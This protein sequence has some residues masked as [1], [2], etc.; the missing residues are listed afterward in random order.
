MILALTARETDFINYSIFFKGNRLKGL[1]RLEAVLQ[2]ADLTNDLVKNPASLPLFLFDK[3]GS[4][5]DLLYVFKQYDYGDAL[6]NGYCESTNKTLDDLLDTV[7]EEALVKIY[8]ISPESRDVVSSDYADKVPLDLLL[9]YCDTDAELIEALVVDSVLFDLILNSEYGDRFLEY[10]AVNSSIASSPS[11]IMALWEGERGAS[12]FQQAAVIET[13][14]N[15]PKMINALCKSSTASVL[16]M[17]NADY[18]PYFEN[19]K[20]SVQDTTYFEHNTASLDYDSDYLYAN[21]AT[22]DSETELTPDACITVAENIAS[23]MSMSGSTY[24]VYR[25][26]ELVDIETGTVRYTGTASGTSGSNTH[27]TLVLRGLKYRGF[28][29]WGTWDIMYKAI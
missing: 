6:I 27:K 25:Q 19:F 29:N 23:Y 20:A 7:A 26:A 8:A 1:S 16:F 11:A 12:L 15:S 21:G 5:K 2:D 4:H 17:D 3:G 28:G 13:I 18:E 9:E 14:S 24:Y 22:Y 10:E